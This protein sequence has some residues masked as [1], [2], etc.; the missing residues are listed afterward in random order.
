MAFG[1][2]P[3]KKKTSSEI[4]VRKTMVAVG[5][6]IRTKETNPEEENRWRSNQTQRHRKERR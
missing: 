6:G 5:R 3:G 4:R 2:F 1:S